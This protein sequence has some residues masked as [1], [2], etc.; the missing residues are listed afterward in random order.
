MF[1]KNCGEELNSNQAVCLKCGCKVGEGSKFCENCGKDLPENAD[2][3]L[4]CGVATDKASD[5]TLPA[6]KD[7]TVAGILAL[8]LGALGIHN[9]YLGETKKGVLKLV[10]SITFIGSFVSAILALVD[11]IKL[12]T[13]KYE[14]NPEKLV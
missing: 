5:G 13:G 14:Y 2:V 7:K 12:F 8:F 6:D 4:N 11:A 1:C 3:C 9:F 10:L